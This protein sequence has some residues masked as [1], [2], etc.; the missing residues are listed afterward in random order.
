MMYHANLC[1]TWIPGIRHIILGLKTKMKSSNITYS[2][3]SESNLLLT[4]RNE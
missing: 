2:Q 3:S 1:N 4:E